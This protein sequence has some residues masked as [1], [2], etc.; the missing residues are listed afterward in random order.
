MVSGELSERPQAGHG[1]QGEGTPEV[2]GGC[3]ELVAV[4]SWRV[5]EAPTLCSMQTAARNLNRRGVLLVLESVTWLVIWSCVVRLRC[6][7]HA[8]EAAEREKDS[9]EGAGRRSGN[10]LAGR[11][12][13]GDRPPM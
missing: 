2:A 11:A 7:D 8:E 13:C 5:D 10:A 1:R 3:A 12:G 6:C 4:E 9:L